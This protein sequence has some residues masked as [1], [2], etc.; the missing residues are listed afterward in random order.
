MSS[1]AALLSLH[2][3]HL[4]LANQVILQS[5]DWQIH[6]KQ[7]IGLL[8]RNG[9]GK[10]TLLQCL[11]GLIAVDSGQIQRQSGLRVAALAQEDP[12]INGICLSRNVGHMAAL[13]CGLDSARGYVFINMDA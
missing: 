12:R 1:T 10:S 3:V 9:A 11:Q 7:R 5:E 2:G 13:A 8:G 6:P 4:V